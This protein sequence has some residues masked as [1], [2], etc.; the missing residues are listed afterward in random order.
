MGHCGLGI[1]G[2]MDQDETGSRLVDWLRDVVEVTADVDD[3]R[4]Q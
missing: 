4:S 3:F 2:V 1:S